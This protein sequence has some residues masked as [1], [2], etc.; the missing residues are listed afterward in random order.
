MSA[1][2][3]ANVGTWSKRSATL[4]RAFSPGFSRLRE[5]VVPGHPVGRRETRTPPERHM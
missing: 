3:T 5:Y 2:D 1:L 4:F